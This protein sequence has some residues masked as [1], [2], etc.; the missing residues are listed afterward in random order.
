MA[1]MTRLTARYSLS[2][3]DR[4]TNSFHMISLLDATTVN[5]ATNSG[6]LYARQIPLSNFDSEEIG[7]KSVLSNNPP[8]RNGKAAYPN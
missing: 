6:S 8:I 5:F 7:C 1:Y 4:L 3:W 2:D